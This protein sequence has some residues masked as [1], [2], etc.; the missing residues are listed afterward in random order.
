MLKF[1]FVRMHEPTAPAWN[2]SELD[3]NSSSPAPLQRSVWNW[4]T[5]RPCTAERD[6]STGKS[7][8]EA[9]LRDLEHEEEERRLNAAYEIAT[10]GSSAVPELVQTLKR[11]VDTTTVERGPANPKGANPA[12]VSALHALCAVGPEAVPA[13]IDLLSV[14][15]N[16]DSRSRCAAAAV[17]GN[18]GPAAADGV[19]ALAA[20]MEDADAIVR[21]NAAEALGTVRVYTDKAA[22]AL[23]KSVGDE[24]RMVRWNGLL[25]IA[26]LGAAVSEDTNEH[27]DDAVP[28]ISAALSDPDR[29]ARFYAEL[30][31]RQI[32]TPRAQSTLINHLQTSRWCPLTTIDSPY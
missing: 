28:A 4:L 32:A 22:G 6:R 27:I 5:G 15:A 23:V 31:L 11:Q 25:A 13:M 21:R 24:D 2:C 12:D 17:L 16:S 18:L 8:R 19:D 10:L 14:G 30:A 29:Y 9:L 26:R 1:M 20:A 7:N 3:W